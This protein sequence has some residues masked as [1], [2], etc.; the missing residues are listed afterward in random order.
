M[1]PEQ[2]PVRQSCELI[3]T[4][5][6]LPPRVGGAEFFTRQPNV[7]QGTREP[8]EHPLNKVPFQIPPM[9]WVINWVYESSDHLELANNP[10][11]EL[12]CKTKVTFDFLPYRE[13]TIEGFKF[14]KD[15]QP[16]KIDPPFRFQTSGLPAKMASQ[17]DF[18]I[19]TK[20]E[21]FICKEEK[22]YSECLDSIQ[23]R[24]LE[25]LKD[26]GGLP[27]TLD[28]AVEQQFDATTQAI[29]TEM[30]DYLINSEGLEMH[31]VVLVKASKNRHKKRT[32]GYR[33]STFRGISKNGR[34]WQV[35]V[36]IDRQKTYL[37]ISNI[38]ARAA[39]LYDVA[40]IQAKGLDAQ[41]NYDY[42]KAQLLAILFQPSLID[43]KAQ[44]KGN[45]SR[46]ITAEIYMNWL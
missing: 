4:L 26:P 21:R 8:T 32:D 43:L 11:A 7:D 27:K 31:S 10:G 41:V 24:S 25:L 13:P 3:E 15:C 12:A 33:G 6:R 18:K 28:Q 34:Q 22:V 23:A 40:V 16:K 19:N 46:S 20:T 14:R 42:S 30:F 1:K 38:K 9:I 29:R 5:G 36:F 44:M 37:C 2:M 17:D 39:R 35:I 45:I